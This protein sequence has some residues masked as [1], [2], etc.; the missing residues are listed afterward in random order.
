M[1]FDPTRLIDLYYLTV[2]SEA[3]KL[4]LIDRDWYAN[5]LK[6]TLEE[7]HF[8]RFTEPKEEIQVKTSPIET[9]FDFLEHA[10][11]LLNHEKGLKTKYS[12]L[13][14][15]N[16]FARHCHKKDE[17]DPSIN[18]ALVLKDMT[19]EDIR[20]IKGCGPRTFRVLQM[21][22]DL[23]NRSQHVYDKWKED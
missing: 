18:L 15:F 12:E 20:A 19:D 16:C 6:L 11:E 23:I 4:G 7:V 2:F 13:R 1:T 5:Y 21:T 10:C 9:F 17:Y 3:N 14:A 22:R 8:T